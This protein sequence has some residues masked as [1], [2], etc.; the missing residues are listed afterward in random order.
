MTKADIL[1]AWGSILRAAI[2]FCRL[3]SP[4]RF[5]GCFPSSSVPAPGSGAYRNSPPMRFAALVSRLVNP[6]ALQK[7]DS[8]SKQYGQE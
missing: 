2:R 4:N 7:R 3:K 6:K 5:S 1:P 8:S